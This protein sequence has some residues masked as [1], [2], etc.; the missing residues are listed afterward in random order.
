MG[1]RRFSTVQGDCWSLSNWGTKLILIWICSSKPSL[2]QNLS[3]AERK[4]K[5]WRD[6]RINFYSM[7]AFQITNDLLLRMG[8]L[9]S[10]TGNMWGGKKKQL[11]SILVR[12]LNKSGSKCEWREGNRISSFSQVA[13]CFLHS[14]I[15][16]IQHKE[17]KVVHLK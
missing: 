10:F 16:V 17:E 6:S 9:Q 7:T 2:D 4:T 5:P 14:N 15:Y 8:P 13:Q 11:E 12:T 3:C 1:W